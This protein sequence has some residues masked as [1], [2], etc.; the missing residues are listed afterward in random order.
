MRYVGFDF[1]GH[2]ARVG[3]RAGGIGAQGARFF[4]Q[5]GVALFQCSDSASH[6]TG[7]VAHGGV[8]RDAR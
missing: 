6:M 3:E 5:A 8:D 2:A 1:Q 4:A 7:T